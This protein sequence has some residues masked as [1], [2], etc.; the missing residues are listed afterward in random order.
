MR[1]ESNQT[2][3][4]IKKGRIARSIDSLQNELDEGARI[5]AVT[6]EDLPENV[7]NVAAQMRETIDS[8]SNRIL[9]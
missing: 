9:N 2:I 8:L 3:D 5:D 4:E 6:L 1:E 7:R